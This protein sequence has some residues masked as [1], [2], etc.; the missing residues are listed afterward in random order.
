MYE[1]GHYTTQHYYNNN[2]LY[3]NPNFFNVRSILFSSANVISFITHEM[4]TP[5][6]IA[7]K[8]NYKEDSSISIDDYISKIATSYSLHLMKIEQNNLISKN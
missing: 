4:V 5:K 2:T 7:R 3:A 1:K 6:D 8:I